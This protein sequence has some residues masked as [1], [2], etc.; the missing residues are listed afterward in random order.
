M[1]AIIIPYYK[2]AFF[3]ETLISLTNQTDKRFK[4]F[5]GDDA[6]PESPL[7][8]LEKYKE[9]VDFVYHR[10]E[11]NLGGFSLTQQWERCISFLGNE[12]WIM[13]LGDDD[14]L[15]SNVV[16]EFYKNLYVIEEKEINVVRF[17]SQKINE[18]SETISEVCK[19]LEIEKAIDFLFTKKR[20]SLSEYIFKKKEVLK[21]GFKNFPLAWYSDVLAVF[22][23][24]NFGAIFSINDSIVYIRVSQF[25]ISGSNLNEKLKLQAQFQFYYYLIKNKKANFTEEELKELYF[26]LKKCYLNNKKKYVFFLKISNIYIHEIKLKE[27]LL[28]I[29]QIFLNTKR[30]Y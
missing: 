1:L 6:S 22:E 19:H 16:E 27:Y 23:F 26:R 25:S 28:F 9:K 20:S 29:K 17:A 30:R 2:L 12:E 3:K 24:S 4:V 7:D 11:T 18:T 13:I 10:F 8:L 21:T 15:E 14:V 5:I